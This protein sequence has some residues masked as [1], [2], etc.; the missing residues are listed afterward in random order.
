MRLAPPRVV[1]GI[2]KQPASAEHHRAVIFKA[3]DL[4]HHLTSLG[5]WQFSIVLAL[6]HYFANSD[7]GVSSYGLHP[8]TFFRGICIFTRHK[9]F[10]MLYLKGVFGEF[11]AL[12]KARK[13]CWRS[14]SLLRALLFIPEHKCPACLWLVLSWGQEL[15]LMGIF[16]SPEDN[17]ILTKPREEE[18]RFT[19]QVLLARNYVSSLTNITS[20]IFTT[21]SLYFYYYL[22]KTRNV[23]IIAI[24][25][26]AQNDKMIRK[27][28][29]DLMSV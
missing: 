25:H 1:Q 11:W 9:G 22:L 13:R 16:T 23:R 14:R 20:F 19:H 3:W 21:T 7:Y 8:L 18:N 4:D 27:Q 5:S 24:E 29:P 28:M 10:L 15:C 6:N 12:F 17:V 2:A 26:I